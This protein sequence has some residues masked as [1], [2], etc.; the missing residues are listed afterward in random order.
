VVDPAVIRRLRPDEWSA[1]RDLRLA[2]LRS[3]PLAFG[4]TYEREAGYPEDRWKGW[5][6][7]GALGAREATFF[8]ESASSEIVGMAGVFPEAEQFHVW[9]MWVRP[10]S[11]GQGLG[12]RLMSAIVRWVESGFPDADLLLQVNPEQAPALNLYRA[13]GFGYTG[14]ESPLGHHPPAVVREMIRP[15][16]RGRGTPGPLSN[17]SSSL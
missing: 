3:D 5:T 1:F 4:S 6:A 13:S 2:A 8:A 9:G 11:R 12:R 10:E 7:G 17:P 14:D 15:G 16:R